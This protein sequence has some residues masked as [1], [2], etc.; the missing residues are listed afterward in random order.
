MSE[1]VV[2]EGNLRFDFTR[3]GKPIKFDAKTYSGL[4][5]VDFLVDKEYLLFIEVKDYQD[6]SSSRVD[7]DYKMLCEVKTSPFA[8]EMGSKIKDSLLSFYAQGKSL[9]KNVVYLL[10]INFDRLSAQERLLLFDKIKG[11]IPYGL[12][13]RHFT[14]FENIKFKLVDATYLKKYG[15]TCEAIA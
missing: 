11:F 4:Y 3:C 9:T 10:F 12:N 6:P 1:Y 5:A 15:I 14:A 13:S 7:D 8:Q 2:E